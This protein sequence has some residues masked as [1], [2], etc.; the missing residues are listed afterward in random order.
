MFITSPPRECSA[1]IPDVENC[2][3]SNESVLKYPSPMPECMSLMSMPLKLYW[4]EPR[5]EPCTEKIDRNG[6]S[7]PP[8]FSLAMTR[9]G[10]CCS[11]DHRSRAEGSVSFSS[12]VQFTSADVFLVSTMGDSPTTV[13]VSD[14]LDTS[15]CRSMVS[16]SPTLMRTSSS[17]IGWKPVN[18][19]FSV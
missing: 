16:A 15:I 6:L 4:C 17:S 19:S 5:M 9:P 10:T 11:V 8:T 14:T 1:E 18:S 2:I 3:S 12:P 13:S 7:M